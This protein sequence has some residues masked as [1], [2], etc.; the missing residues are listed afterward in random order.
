MFCGGKCIEINLKMGEFEN[1]K[2]GMY[3]R[4]FLFSTGSL[5]W[6]ATDGG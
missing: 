5:N 1:L 3:G 6:G 4:F 2:M